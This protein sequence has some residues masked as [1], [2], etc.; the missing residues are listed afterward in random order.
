MTTSGRWCHM[1]LLD[2][3]T[4]VGGWQLG[5]P[6]RCPCSGQAS[7]VD[8]DG[9]L[10]SPPGH[11]VF[12]A[13]HLA[14]FRLH[15]W[16]VLPRCSPTAVLGC[17]P[18]VCSL[19]L[20]PRLLL[21][22]PMY[23][24]SQLSHF[25]WYTTPDLSHEVFCPLVSLVSLFVCLLVSSW[26]VDTP[27]FCWKFAEAV[28]IDLVSTECRHSMCVFLVCGWFAGLFFIVSLWTSSHNHYLFFSAHFSY[29]LSPLSC[30]VLQRQPGPPAP[31]VFLSR[32][33]NLCSN[34][35]FEFQFKYWSVCVAFLYTWIFVDP[36]FFTVTL[37]SKKLIALFSGT[38]MVNLMLLS[39][40]LM[41]SLNSA[42]SDTS[43]F[44]WLW[45]CRPHVS[46]I[47]LEWCCW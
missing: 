24:L 9:L 21:V 12:F 29:I 11:M 35:W 28:L 10:D 5:C 33:F 13:Q 17:R 14:S 16:S 27:C 7:L 47:N 43:Y 18:A 34:G 42:C 44:E 30:L 8:S 26:Y 39:M 15:L 20:V 37:V 46:A 45:R 23:I 38:S 36:S 25:S 31:I 40:S 41:C 22:S 3:V 1:T 32:T 2:H 6:G 19:Y 4:P